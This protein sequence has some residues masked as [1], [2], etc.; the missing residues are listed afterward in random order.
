M[1]RLSAVR[2][3]ALGLPRVLG[4]ASRTGAA[5]GVARL[6]VP[7][8]GRALATVRRLRVTIHAEGVTASGQH[9]TQDIELTL[10][11]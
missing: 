2:A 4:R 3:S 8:R 9:V 10:R 1:V 11:A 5:D 7:L 6:R